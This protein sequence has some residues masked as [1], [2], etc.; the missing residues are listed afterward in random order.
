MTSFAYFRLINRNKRSVTVDLKHPQGI[1][2]VEEL[3]RVSDIVID[4]FTP[5]VMD[6]IGLGP[7]RL[8]ELNEHVITLSL[9]AAGAGGPHSALKGYGASISSLGGM[10]ALSGYETGEV[11]GTLGA[12]ISDPSAAA[13]GVLSVL[14][15]LVAQR[16]GTSTGTWI[17]LSQTEA[18]AA[19]LGEAF[20]YLMVTGSPPTP[21]GNAHPVFFPHGMYRCSGDD[22]WIAVAARDASERARL[23]SVVVPASDSMSLDNSESTGTWDMYVSAWTG[24]RSREQAVDEL[25][26]AGVPCAPVRDG[27]EVVADQALVDRGVVAIVNGDRVPLAPW[28]LSGTPV[29]CRLPAPGIG[30]HTDEV[31]AE[32]LGYSEE[33]R[34]ELRELEVLE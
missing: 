5:G 28:K 13:Y 21:R 10:E 23:R 9:S 14:A 34:A 19:S 11:V 30:E 31:L 24:A 7:E 3:V 12:N 20:G 27:A 18:V 15:S 29:R 25:R 32:L 6:R 22:R 2:V 16:R 33:R 17:D 4:N 8:L 1:G 26:A